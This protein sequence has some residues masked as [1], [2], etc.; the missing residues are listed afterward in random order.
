MIMQVIVMKHQLGRETFCLLRF[1]SSFPLHIIIKNKYDSAIFWIHH[2][3][4]SKP[5]HES[6][7]GSFSYLSTYLQDIQ[8]L[9]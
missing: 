6:A 5:V 8:S 2:T 7:D 9:L 3:F 1:R 4:R